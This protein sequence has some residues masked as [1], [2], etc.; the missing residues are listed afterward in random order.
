MRGESGNAKR[1]GNS[2]LLLDLQDASEYLRSVGYSVERISSESVLGNEGLFFATTYQFETLEMCS[3]L[4]M[5]DSTHCTNRYGWKWFTLY[6]RDHCMSWNVGGHFLV[7]NED[8]DIVSSGLKVVRKHAPKW[9]L[10]YFLTDDSNIKQ[11]AI[12]AAFP[13]LVAGEKNVDLLLCAVYVMGN[14]MRKIYH[15]KTR[16]LMIKVMH[17]T[18]KIACEE[19]LDE[20]INCPLAPMRDY[21]NR[22]YRDHT[23]KWA[24]WNR[25]HSPILLQ[26]PS[27]ILP[28]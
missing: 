27:G 11:N 18:T 9:K 21:I 19:L 14:W 1:V 26:T 5:M 16:A 6:A 20:A 7:S 10:R 4:T 8:S 13:R 23:H 2:D 3:W 12:T 22:H 24:L 17:K 25:Q 28:L 15:A